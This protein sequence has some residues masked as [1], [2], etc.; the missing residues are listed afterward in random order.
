MEIL[1]QTFLLWKIDIDKRA[2]SVE[3]FGITSEKVFVERSDT[4]KVSK[5]IG[6]VQMEGLVYFVWL[7]QDAWRPFDAKINL[8]L[9]KTIHETNIV[10]IGTVRM[11][12][13]W[14]TDGVLSNVFVLKI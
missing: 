9:W 11:E 4:K 5:S 10:V 13:Y 2:D 14:L 12:T 3:M 8:I 7:L 6:L 1:L